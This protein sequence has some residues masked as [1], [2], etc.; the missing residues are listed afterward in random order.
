MSN[1]FL[2]S[3]LKNLLD[4]VTENTIDLPQ[5]IN[6]VNKNNV[7]ES[8]TKKTNLSATSDVQVGD[9]EF[10][11]TSDYQVGGGCDHDHDKIEFSATSDYQVGGGGCNGGNDDHDKIEFSATSDYQVGGDCDHDHN[12]IEFSAT[13][14]YQVG[15]DCDDCG[16]SHDHQLAYSETSDYQVGGGIDSY[17]SDTSIDQSSNKNNELLGGNTNS[18][19]DINNLIAMLTSDSETELNKSSDFDTVV[20][21]SSTET[22]QNKI[23]DLLAQKGGHNNFDSIESLTNTDTLEQ[24][25]SN[26][27]T[28][29]GAGKKKKKSKKK[30][31]KI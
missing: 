31:K 3:S 17:L 13:S 19:S 28:Q 22:I 18:K 14:D 25:I 21:L 9:S 20:S 6:V 10:S 16:N 5:W 11:A 23:N 26:I 24:K 29:E 1:I 30:E 12:K 4:S 2:K 27:F 8:I 15:G 7:T